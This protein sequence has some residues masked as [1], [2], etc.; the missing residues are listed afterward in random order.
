M[1]P[2]RRDSLG[3]SLLTVATPLSD[4]IINQVKDTSSFPQATGQLHRME[5]VLDGFE[6]NIN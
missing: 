5:W 1:F 4:L 6:T 3:P 2:A